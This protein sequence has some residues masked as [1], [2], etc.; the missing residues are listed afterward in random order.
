MQLRLERCHRKVGVERRRRYWTVYD[1][2]VFPV[3][4]RSKL[5]A[6]SCADRA[7]EPHGHTLIF[8]IE[9]VPARRR[10]NRRIRR[11]L[12]LMYAKHVS[13]DPVG[14]VPIG[15]P[16][17]GKRILKRAQIVRFGRLAPVRRL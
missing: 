15:E 17:R 9:V 1:R 12:F 10:E 3:I 11:I 4:R 8:A 6:L 2:C 7:D 13:V 5:D 16:L 14:I